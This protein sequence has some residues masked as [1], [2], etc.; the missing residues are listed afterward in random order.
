[1]KIEVTNDML[2][3][4]AIQLIKDIEHISFLGDASTCI[5]I[6]HMAKTWLKQIDDTKMSGTV[7]EGEE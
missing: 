5:K 6:S 2:L 7:N 1:M 3:G 4:S